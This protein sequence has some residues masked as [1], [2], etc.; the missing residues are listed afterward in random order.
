[1]IQK[2][3]EDK[4]MENFTIHSIGATLFA[5]LTYFIGGWDQFLPLLVILVSLDIIGG[6][7]ISFK[8]GNFSSKVMIHGILKKLYM[9][10]VIAAAYQIGIVVGFP[11]LREAFTSYYA[12]GE[13]ISIMKNSTEFGLSYPEKIMEFLEKFKEK[14]NEISP[15]E[16]KGE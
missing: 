1:M 8:K 6:L 11:L 12:V 10:I 15:D 9:F 5:A 3:K 7:M 14:L 2:H 16:K 4:I 13:A